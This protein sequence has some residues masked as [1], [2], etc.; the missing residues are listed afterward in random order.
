MLTGHARQ[1]EFDAGEMEESLNVPDADCDNESEEIIDGESDNAD[2]PMVRLAT[3][4]RQRE[5]SL[6]IESMQMID[7]NFK[8]FV[9]GSGRSMACLTAV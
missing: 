8:A 4:A 1:Q 7:H 2:D 3:Q 6:F 5:L 9:L